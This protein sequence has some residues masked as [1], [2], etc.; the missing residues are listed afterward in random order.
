ML[1]AAHTLR[2]A[3]VCLWDVDI[4]TQTNAAA[5]QPLANYTQLL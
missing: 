2:V 3:A 1:R 4:I 5:A